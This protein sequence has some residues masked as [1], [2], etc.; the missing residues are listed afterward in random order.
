MQISCTDLSE[1]NSAMVKYISVFNLFIDTWDSGIHLEKDI[2]SVPFGHTVAR[3]VCL[4]E[5]V[6]ATRICTRAYFIS[7]LHQ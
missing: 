4:F 5:M 6:C 2:I 1:R 3:T 7:G